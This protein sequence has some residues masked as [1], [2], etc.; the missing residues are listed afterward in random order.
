VRKA[1]YLGGS[2]EY[3]LDTD[4]GELFAVSLDV[5]HPRAVGAEVGVALADHGVV[6]IPRA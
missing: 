2:V 1:T 4:I 6:V 5:A 3:T